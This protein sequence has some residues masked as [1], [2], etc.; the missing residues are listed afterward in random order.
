MPILIFTG[1][2]SNLVIEYQPYH[3]VKNLIFQPNQDPFSNQENLLYHKWDN[4]K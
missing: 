2:E 1:I 3:Q 4:R